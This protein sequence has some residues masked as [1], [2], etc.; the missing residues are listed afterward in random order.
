MKDMQRVQISGWKNK[1]KQ[2]SMLT[3]VGENA[4]KNA[5]ASMTTSPFWSLIWDTSCDVTRREQGAVLIRHLEA[6]CCSAT[7]TFVT[8]VEVPDTTAEGEERLLR[9]TLGNLPFRPT[10]AG[11]AAGLD[12][13][14]VNMGR[15]NGLAKRLGV[16]ATHCGGHKTDLSVTHV[17]KELDRVARLNE[18]LSSVATDL[19]ASSK[20]ANQLRSIQKAL[21]G[22]TREFLS[23]P[24]TR[25]IELLRTCERYNQIV[26][27]LDILYEQRAVEGVA[28]ANGR[29]RRIRNVRLL[30]LSFLLVDVLSPVK[31]LNKSQQRKDVLICE[32]ISDVTRVKKYLTRLLEHKDKT[33]KEFWKKLNLTEMKFE[34]KNHIIQLESRGIAREDV[35]DRLIKDRAETIEAFLDDFKDFFQTNDW[36]VFDI[37]QFPEKNMTGYGDREIGALYDRFSKDVVYLHIPEEGNAQTVK[38]PLLAA[39]QKQLI[40]QGC[41]FYLISL[42]FL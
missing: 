27:D 2:R 3:L 33:E 41:F 30:Y 24:D 40:L 4:L 35:E 42:N 6:G 38:G 39:D 20:L 29:L 9:S 26:G 31:L 18:H 5:H 32:L 12:G 13:A 15:H 34:A 8:L 37:T 7:E 11:V 10:G 17:K 23:T 21:Q 1:E 36:Q 28:S 19:W 14:S 16:P 25:W 22:E